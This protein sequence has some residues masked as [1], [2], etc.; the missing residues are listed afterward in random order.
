MQRLGASS[1]SD[2]HCCRRPRR[3]AA[4]RR[5]GKR[6]PRRRKGCRGRCRRRRAP[7]ASRARARRPGARASLRPGPA[8][9]ARGATV[10]QEDQREHQR[11]VD[12][13]VGRF[14]QQA[15]AGG[16]VVEG[17]R[18]R[19]A[20]AASATDAGPPRAPRGAAPARASS[21]DCAAAR[22]SI[23][24]G[25][26]HAGSSRGCLGPPRVC[27]RSRP[28]VTG[29]TR[30]PATAAGRPPGRSARPPGAGVCR[31]RRARSRG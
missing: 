9:G 12:A 20:A 27:R 14:L 6:D 11:E 5:R 2:H 7:A 30:P 21:G 29:A 23:R 31:C 17:S 10:D 28:A 1:K 16:V 13:A 19:P 25:C 15:E 3:S 26:R 18:A 4:G 24:L 8:P 22:G